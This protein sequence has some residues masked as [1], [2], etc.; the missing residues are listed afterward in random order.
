MSNKL[1]FKAQFVL[2]LKALGKLLWN[3]LMTQLSRVCWAVFTWMFFFFVITKWVETSQHCG[4]GTSVCHVVTLTLICLIG[5]PHMDKQESMWWFHSCKY[6]HLL[7]SSPIWMI[8]IS[9]ENQS[10]KCNIQMTYPGWWIRTIQMG[11]GRALIL[12]I[13]SMMMQFFGSTDHD[14][15]LLAAH[16]DTHC[17]EN[18]WGGQSLVIKSVIHFHLFR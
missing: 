6:K 10:G 11:Y 16:W 8:N 9:M 12:Q 18:L 7:K 4:P 3:S 15:C 2:T 13:W 17:W 5:C 1:L 14:W